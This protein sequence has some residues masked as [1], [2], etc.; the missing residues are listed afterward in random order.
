VP[1][2]AG[3]GSSWWSADLIHYWGFHTGTRGDLGGLC[4]RVRGHTVDT[5]RTQLQLS[6]VNY[7]DVFSQLGLGLDR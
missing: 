7:G 6:S 2:S 4:N 1:Q 3:N 5:I